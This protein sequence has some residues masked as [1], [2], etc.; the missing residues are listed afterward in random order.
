[1]LYTIFENTFQI[2]DIEKIY[3]Y[4]CVLAYDYQNENKKPIFNE[5]IT[6]LT[7]DQTDKYLFAGSNDGELK[8]FEIETIVNNIKCNVISEYIIESETKWEG[9]KVDKNKIFCLTIDANN[10]YLFVGVGFDI[11]VFDI[12]GSI[13]KNFGKRHMHTVV[14]HKDLIREIILTN[15]NQYLLSGGCDRNIHVFEIQTKNLQN[16]KKEK[17]KDSDSNPGK[18]L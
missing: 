8:V 3:S 10:E 7:I 6:C 4:K 18:Q 14:K 9:I 15:N 11:L 5:N 1:M 13:P 2:I 12:K 17:K 16:H